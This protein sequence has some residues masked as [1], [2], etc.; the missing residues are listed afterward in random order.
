MSLSRLKY[1]VKISIQS[2]AYVQLAHYIVFVVLLALY[3]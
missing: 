3:S 2:S 1:L